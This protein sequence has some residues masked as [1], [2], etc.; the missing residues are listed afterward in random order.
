M[1]GGFEV[2][3]L[4]LQARFEFDPGGSGNP[5]VR[6]SRQDG[7]QWEREFSDLER[8]PSGPETHIDG[9]RPAGEWQLVL[10]G[11]KA[12]SLVSFPKEQVERAYTSWGLRTARSVTFGLWS[13]IKVLK[14]GEILRLDCAVLTQSR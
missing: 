9:A 13:P 10:G 12:A 8:D 2:V 5:T 6:F 1:N 14:S 11:S 4:A 7:G 3:S